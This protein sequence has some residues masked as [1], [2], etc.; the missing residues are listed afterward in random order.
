M[1]INILC[2]LIILFRIFM[3]EQWWFDHPIQFMY[4]VKTTM[5]DATVGY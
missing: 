5:R 3:Q 4:K 2:D 1:N